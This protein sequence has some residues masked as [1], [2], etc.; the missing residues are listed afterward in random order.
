MPENAGLRILG[1]PQEAKEAGLSG[2]IYVAEADGSFEPPP[3][4]ILR[5]KSLVV[6]VG[7]KRGTSAAEIGAAVDKVFQDHELSLL[8]VR[9]LATVELKKDEDGLN[10]L[11]RARDWQAVYYSVSELQS[12]VPVPS[13]SEKVRKHLGVESV[14]EKAALIN[15]GVEELLIPKQILGNVTVAVARVTSW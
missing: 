1:R 13:P 15:A 6:G 10:E 3:C 7:C 4:L 11:L 12:P 5:P 2:W 8:A 9:N 14:C